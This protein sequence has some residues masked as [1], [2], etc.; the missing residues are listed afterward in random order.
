MSEDY[1]YAAI[2]EFDNRE[3]FEAYL[4]HPAHVGLATRF[5]AS[6]ETVLIYDYEISVD[7]LETTN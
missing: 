1:T 3:A 6:F 5:F 7:P 4:D 2:I